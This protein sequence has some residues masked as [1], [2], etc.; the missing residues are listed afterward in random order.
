MFEDKH[1]F[2]HP[3]VDVG[4]TFRAVSQNVKAKKIVSGGSTITMQVIRMA[5]KIVNV[6]IS[7]N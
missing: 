2:V 7:K 1:F 4:S 6:L 5:R 3:G